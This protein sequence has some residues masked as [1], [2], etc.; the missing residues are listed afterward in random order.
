MSFRR[1]YGISEFEWDEKFKA[2]G[3]KCANSG[4]QA[5]KPGNK[6][7]WHTD[8]CHKTGKLRGI[9]CSGCNVALGQVNDSYS[10][11]IGLIY[12]LKTHNA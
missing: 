4:C 7:G 12:Y 6:K 8:H 11:L 5:D 2:Q 9:L 1:N 3:R 10:K